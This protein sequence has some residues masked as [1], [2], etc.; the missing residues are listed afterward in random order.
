M[1]DNN[2]KPILKNTDNKETEDQ[3][4]DPNIK[5]PEDQNISQ[6]QTDTKNAQELY[7]K[8][9]KDLGLSE[10]ALRK[11][12]GNI[13]YWVLGVENQRNFKMQND[14]DKEKEYKLK[15]QNEIKNQIEEL[16]NDSANEQ[17]ISYFNTKIAQQENLF[18]KYYA[19]NE[20]ITSKINELKNNIPFLDQRVKFANQQLKKL[21]KENLKLM[22]Q[23]SKIETELSYLNSN[24]YYENFPEQNLNINNNNSI[25]TS[26]LNT[27]NNNEYQNN[28][29]SF[30]SINLNE[31]MEEND[32][33][34]NKYNNIVQLKKILTNKKKENRHL[35]KSIT[36]MNTEYFTYKKMFNEGMHEIAKELLKIHEM[37][38]DKVINSNTNNNEQNE[39]VNSLYF[40]MVKGNYKGNCSKNDDT[41]KL[42]LINSNIKKKYNFPLIEKRTPEALIYNVIKKMMDES[43]SLNKMMNLRKN[44]FTWEEFKDFSA[45][46]IFTILNLNKNVVKKLENYLFPNKVVFPQDLE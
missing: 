32:E 4:E 28:D 27:N 31:V 11:A 19:M 38:L 46:Q 23:I 24:N 29:G 22:D 34:K 16:S 17:L 21:N 37:Q 20:E 26:V 9:R 3:K 1:S 44:K 40:E 15:E 12:M 13:E 10:F 35:M 2:P 33:I 7:E 39:N 30:E 6:N 14:F 25:A 18:K 43:H 5:N 36:E 45:Y 41:L 8:L 42:P